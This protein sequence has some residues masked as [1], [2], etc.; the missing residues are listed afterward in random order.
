MSGELSAKKLSAIL[1]VVSIGAFMDGLDGAIVNVSLPHIAAEFNADLGLV[2]LVLTVYFIALS[3]LMIIF[4]KASAYTG[5]KKL[6]IIGIAVFTISSLF[7]AVSWSIEVLIIW[8]AVQGVGAAMVAPSAIAIIAMQ[9][10][11]EMRGRSLGIIAAASALAFA[12]GPVVGGLLTEFLS[13]HWIFLINLPIGVFT[14]IAAHHVLA[15]SVPPARKKF[16]YMGSAAFFTAMALLV[17]PLSM[18]GRGGISDA[19]V[20]L[21]LAGSITLFIVFVLIEKR[22]EDPV[23]E[24]A[25]FLNR[26]FSLSVSSYMLLMLAYGGAI[27]LLPFY[28]QS[29]LEMGPGL[30]GMFL[31][32]PS[33]VITVTSPLGGYFS[34]ISGAR[35]VCS[36]SAL[37]FLASFILIAGFVSDTALWFIIVSL[38]VMG[39][40]A[41][42]FMSAG[43]SRIIEHADPDKR[44]IAS[45][46]MSTAI[47]FGSAL[48]TSL[49][50]AIFMQSAGLTGEGRISAG[51]SPGLFVTGYESAFLFGIICCAAV[52]IFSA[53]AG[54]RKKSV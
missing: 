23:I 24:P 7:C 49:F 12:L 38:I 42:P 26:N 14:V 22:A 30:A 52:L 18:A 5:T 6:F 13:W 3:G 28:F 11:E 1:G 47:Y 15:E 10:P 25:M 43:S 29:L 4:G 21:P 8:R 44:E 50:T 48:G 39:L 34:D 40:G 36:V 16:D 51:I 41:G 33:V 45:G 54:D 20:C 2:S 19:S 31:L 53:L 9:F 37:V 35:R 17:I 46:I 27:L 32:V